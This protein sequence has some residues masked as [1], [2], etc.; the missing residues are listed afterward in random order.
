[1]WPNMRQNVGWKW[2]ELKHKN[3]HCG[4]L[5]TAER[6]AGK[7]KMMSADM[8]GCW[9]HLLQDCPQLEHIFIMIKCINWLMSCSPFLFLC[10]MISFCTYGRSHIHLDSAS[11][12]LCQPNVT[13][14]GRAAGCGAVILAT[15][16]WG[17]RSGGRKRWIDEE[18]KGWSDWSGSCYPPLESFPRPC[19]R[20]ENQ[21]HWSLKFL[22][23]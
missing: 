18:S 22:M 17:E 8:L 12:T 21:A 7:I 15:G 2:A 11:G 23:W 13:L 10:W 5:R 9:W 16:L 6:N 20:L 4:A 1:M 3:V 14:T 19:P